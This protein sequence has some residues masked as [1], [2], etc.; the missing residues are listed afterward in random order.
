M[1][2]LDYIGKTPLVKLRY[3]P[4]GYADVY[5]KLESANPGGSIK[6]R[7]A[8][9]MIENAEKRG[10]IKPGDTIIEATG[11]NTGIGLAIACNVKGYKLLAVVPDNYSKE[12][13]KKL[14]IYGAKVLLSDS[15]MGNDS[16]IKLVKQLL[17]EHPEYVWLNQFQN[18]A[19]IRAHFEGTGPEI[20][21]Q[22]QPDAFV[23][24]IGSAG[25]FQGIGSF[26]KQKNEDI[27]LFAVQPKGCDLRIGTAVPHK[28]QGVSL[29]IVPPL[30][31]YEIISGYIDVEFEEVRRLLL[32]L[33][34]KEGLFLGIS[35]GANI[36]GAL[37]LA[38]K[39]GQGKIVCTIAPDS[40]D[41][42][43]NEFIERQ[44]D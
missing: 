31:D 42:Y 29:G 43:L 5:V 23:A 22:I 44:E 32:Q 14:S 21:E 17:E 11:G 30:L 2:V 18:P 9:K 34:R 10:L 19:S 36:L 33:I 38:K 27:L 12:R 8:A 35:S 15:R 26:L 39:L 13:I 1:N 24:C 37:I 3:L 4:Q 6:T 41:N 7:V 20:Y 28:I 16:H 25:S 40:G